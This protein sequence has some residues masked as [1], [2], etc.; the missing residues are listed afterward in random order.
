MLRQKKALPRTI[1]QSMMK[2]SLT[3]AGYNILYG[4]ARAGTDNSAHIGGVLGG[5]VLGWLLALPLDREIRLRETGRKLQLGLVTLGVLTGLGVAFTPR[6]DYRVKEVL[7]WD[8]TNQSFAPQETELLKQQ[9]QSFKLLAQGK[10]DPAYVAWPPKPPWC[11]FYE[12]WAKAVSNLQLAQDKST[13][14]LQAGMLTIFQLKIAS[15]R[16]LA[17]GVRAHDRDVIAGFAKRS[18]ANV[19]REIEKLHAMSK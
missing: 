13:A 15:Y 6:F 3:F 11:L 14:R 10:P 18:D 2:S 16:H 17:A 12:N 5:F 7:A 9:E 8:D 1:Y 4:M 19:T